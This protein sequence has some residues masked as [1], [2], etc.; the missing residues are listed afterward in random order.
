VRRALAICLLTAAVGCGADDEHEVFAAK[1]NEVC[2]RH[3]QQVRSLESPQSF[4]QLLDY[5]DEIAAL[6]RQ[7]VEEL[8]AIDPPAEDEPEFDR[9]VA[10]MER[11]LAFY[12]ELR[13]AATTGRPS[14]I[15]AVLRK[16]DVSDARAGKLGRGLG[17][18]E[19]VGSSEGGGSEGAASAP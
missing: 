19:C 16:A 8:Q 15:Q 10:Q 1:A 3:A 5:V 6:A 11:T 2:R 9:M 7:Q 14:A 4:D 13:E 12:P 17:L 18:D